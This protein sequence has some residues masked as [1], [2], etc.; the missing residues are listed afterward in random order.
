MYEKA[1][2]LHM[3]QSGPEKPGGQSQLTCEL[4]TCGVQVPPNSHVPFW[5]LFS[6]YHIQCTLNMLVIRRHIFNSYLVNRLYEGRSIS[7]RTVL[8]IKH[9]ANTEYQ[10]YSQV[11][12]P[13][14]YHGFIY[15]II[16]IQM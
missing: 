3:S 1:A 16:I 12:P 4:P 15:D 10:N 9:Q 8:L 6:V 11:V 14:I 5:H 7:S 2:S 13:L